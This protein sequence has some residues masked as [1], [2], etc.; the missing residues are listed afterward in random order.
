MD[1]TP[2]RKGENL[3]DR[4]PSQGMFAYRAG[5]QRVADLLGVGSA[6]CHIGRVLDLKLAEDFGILVS[7]RC[8]EFRTAFSSLNSNTSCL[9]VI[10]TY[11]T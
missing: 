9:R 8:V 3:C 2:G 6:H 7:S 10:D 4:R 5:R 11:L 1:L